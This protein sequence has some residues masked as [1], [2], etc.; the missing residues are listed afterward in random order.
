MECSHIL[1]TCKHTQDS[2]PSGE[3]KY[4]CERCLKAR[5]EFHAAG[6]ARLWRSLRIFLARFH[7]GAVLQRASQ[8]TVCGAAISL[9]PR[10][11][12]FGQWAREGCHAGV[13]AKESG[14]SI[15]PSAR[16][17]EDSRRKPTCFV[18]GPEIEWALVDLRDGG[19]RPLLVTELVRR[20]KRGSVHG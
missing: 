13:D 1:G 7:S 3:F 12:T 5:I 8:R 19:I 14:E 11:G 16:T 15:R 10:R 18:H 2:E 6:A 9:C 17:R 4:I 20:G